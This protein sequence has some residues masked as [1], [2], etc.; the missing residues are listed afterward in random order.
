M[1]FTNGTLTPTLRGELFSWGAMAGAVSREVGGTGAEYG[2]LGGTAGV[3][4]RMVVVS[5]E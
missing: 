1:L 5:R 2:A 3:C 4:H